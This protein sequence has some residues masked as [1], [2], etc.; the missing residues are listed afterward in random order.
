MTP[1]RAEA[2]AKKLI[3]KHLNAR[4]RFEWH[5]GLASAGICDCYNKIIKLSHGITEVTPAYYVRMTTLHEIAHALTSR[6]PGHGPKWRAMCRELGCS[7]QEKMTTVERRYADRACRRRKRR[8]A[9]GDG[10]P[11]R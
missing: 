6:E 1:A 3:A 9:T 10:R 5:W 11:S 7:Q 2:S 4:W 8:P